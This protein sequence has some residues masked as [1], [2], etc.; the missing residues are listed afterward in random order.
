LTAQ[1]TI[2]AGQNVKPDVNAKAV[3]AESL[4][5]SA[6][7]IE[8]KPAKFAV[9][10]LAVPDTATETSK[11]IPAATTPVASSANTETNKG[12]STVAPLLV[13]EAKTE[14]SKSVLADTTPNTLSAITPHASG[15]LNSLPIKHDLPLSVPT[16]I[17]DQGWAGD[18]GQKILWLASSDKQSAQMT[19]NP[20]QMGPIEISLN[21]DKGNAT[22]SFVS[23]NAEV[24]QAIEAA[25]PRLREMFASAG[26]ALGQTNVSSESFRQQSGSG[27]GYRSASQGMVD[28]A[29]LV[30]GSAGSLPARAFATQQGNGLVNTFA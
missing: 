26:I 28:N 30:T 4:P 2:T 10:P 21:M 23:G 5:A 27:D 15:N 1:Q 24:R 9:T 7:A 16:P 8:D 18:F 11:S 19:L 17:R 13:A 29:I 20:P 6:L 25:M 14:T 12:V 22:A 3:N